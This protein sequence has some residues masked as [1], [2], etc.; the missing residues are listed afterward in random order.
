MKPAFQ[1]RLPGTPLGVRTLRRQLSAI[2]V[3][4]GMSPDE[5]ADV[6]LAVSEA[7]TNAVMHA[8][9]DTE[10]EL[11]VS[12]AVGDGKLEIVIGDTGEGFVEGRDSPGLGVGLSIIATVAERLRIVSRP[13]GTEIHMAFPCPDSAGA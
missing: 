6:R 11:V 1:A 3:D 12:A 7:A 2:A 4:C 10:G 9:A 8:Y 5:V 13:G